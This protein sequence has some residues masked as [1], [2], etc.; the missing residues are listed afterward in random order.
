MKMCARYDF[1]ERRL[2]AKPGEHQGNERKR[3]QN[4]ADQDDHEENGGIPLWLDGHDP[5]H[6]CKRRAERINDD[7]RPAQGAHPDGWAR[8]GGCVLLQR[9]FAQAI[10][11]QQPEPQKENGARRK[12]MLEFR[13]IAFRCNVSLAA[14]ASGRAHG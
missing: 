8:L 4:L 9:P 13:Y 7:A 5:I 1:A 10:G 2:I 14:T 12:T 11:H 6:E 3:G